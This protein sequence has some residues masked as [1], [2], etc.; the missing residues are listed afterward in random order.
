ML[1]GGVEGHNIGI[2]KPI[3]STTLNSISLLLVRRLGGEANV[4]LFAVGDRGGCSTKDAANRRL[5]LPP[6]TAGGPK[7]PHA[8][9]CL[10]DADRRF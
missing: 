10:K 5:S 9:A 1:N 8:T 6:A 3:S 4:S 2:R 7:A